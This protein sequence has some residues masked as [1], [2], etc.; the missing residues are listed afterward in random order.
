M[1][2]DQGRSLLRGHAQGDQGKLAFTARAMFLVALPC[3]EAHRGLGRKVVFFNP[4]RYLLRGG[5]P[6][7]SM[8][9]LVI[10]HAAPFHTLDMSGTFCSLRW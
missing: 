10:T 2:K 4:L 9:T 8:I 1:F 5:I 6:V 3:C 7:Q